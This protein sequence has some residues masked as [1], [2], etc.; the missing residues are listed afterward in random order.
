MKRL[1]LTFLALVA[2]TAG[3]WAQTDYGFRI[4][5]IGINS[6]NYQSLS[7]G[8]AWYYDP[9][10]NVLHLTEGQLYCNE[11][12]MILIYENVNPS[13]NISVDGNCEM[14]GIYT[15][16]IGFIG[17]G[18]GYHTIYGSGTL[19]M[20]SQRI[21]PTMLWS[22]GGTQTHLTI[23]DITLN[24]K[25]YGDASRGIDSHNF[26]S[27]T[28]DNCEANIITSR[29][30]Y[31]STDAYTG[32]SPTFIK[33]FL[34][35]G[36]PGTQ[37]TEY[38]NGEYALLK[39]AHIKRTIN[40]VSVT[41]EAPQTGNAPSTNIVTDSEDYYAT[42][43]E[44]YHNYS[45]EYS[46]RMLEDETYAEG[47][48]YKVIFA[49]KP[50]EG[51]R[52]WNAAEMTA[53]VNGHPA[54]IDGANGDAL[55]IQ[56]TFPALSDTYD[57]WIAGTQVTKQNRDDILGDGKVTFDMNTSTLTLQN[58][59]ISL[60]GNDGIT[61][62]VPDLKIKVL[63]QNS[64]TIANSGRGVSIDNDSGDGSVTFLG[65]GSLYV[66]SQRGA[67]IRSNIDVVLK[68]GVKIITE[69]RQNSSIRGWKSTSSAPWPSLTMYG[70]KTIL[71]AKGSV[72][73]F[74]SLNLNDG[75]SITRPAGARYVADDG[76][77]VGSNKVTDKWVV[78][79][80]LVPGDA[81]FDGV[82]DIADVT[83]VLSAMASNSDAPQF[84]VNEDDAV[85]IA[86]VT[87]ILT[88]MAGQ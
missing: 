27:I 15:A 17:E 85:D 67:G 49:L 31:W 14:E 38:I 68:D 84:K 83:A 20:E 60:S 7:S 51:N 21:N 33:C 35:S 74:H 29:S 1:L 46:F 43:V 75:L 50:T 12:E 39:E 73:S 63:G 25:A 3:A 66:K 16:A 2:M 62:K 23:K 22:Q 81:N 26:A 24:I 69:S 37:F 52:F 34:T 76:V 55:I 8:E 19:S 88:I 61:S 78:I 65:D 42:I 36:F 59:N 79:G 32:A 80:D 18:E 54:I 57:L 40:S 58:A 53:Y 45:S 77:Y 30:A 4:K 11:T 6:S 87:A 28:F 13:L 47:N 9:V 82:I 10:A 5:G 71:I 72:G 48:I 44:W 70:D 56:Y 41:V 64:I 86:D